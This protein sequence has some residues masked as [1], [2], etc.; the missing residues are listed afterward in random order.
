MN[1]HFINRSTKETIDITNLVEKASVNGEYRNACRTLDFTLVSSTW[2]VN[3]P[4]PDIKLGD[5]IGLIENNL[6]FFYGVVWSITKSTTSSTVNYHCKDF[7]V[8][9][10]KNKITD[11]FV[12]KT[13]ESITMDIC[14]RYNIEVGSLYNTGHN[15]TRKFNSNGLYDVIMTLYHLTH[16]GEYMVRFS[17]KALTVVKKG[18][19]VANKQLEKWNDLLTASNNQTLDSMVNTVYVMDEK[20]ENVVDTIQNK[21]NLIYG[22]LSETINKSK[23]ENYKD[24]SNKLLKGVDNKI[25]VTN[26][27]D[28]QFIT[29]NAV[30]LTEKWT[31]LEG[32]FYID[33][34]THTWERGLYTNNLTLNFKN[35]SDEKEVGSEI[36]DSQD[37]KSSK[38]ESTNKKVGSKKSN[39]KKA[40]ISDL[41]F[42]LD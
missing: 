38:K 32:L 1:L 26:F 29:G 37:N 14:N 25:N 20:S 41:K 36:K 6:L 17:G 2:D 8:Y 3:I 16:T 33:S 4:R 42:Y 11:K 18:E 30:V 24:K 23:D 9:L 13:P 21:E 28:I 31:G 27:G 39:N 19:I 10:L 34:D 7:G 12:N 22:L 15:I 40:S 5:N 35:L